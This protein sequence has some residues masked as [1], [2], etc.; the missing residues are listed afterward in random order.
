MLTIDIYLGLRQSNGRYT[1]NL[2][3]KQVE[4]LWVIALHSDRM[5]RLIS[6]LLDLDQAEQGDLKI[7]L[8]VCNVNTVMDKVLEA[9]SSLAHD[10]KIVIDCDLPEIPLRLRDDA[11]ALWRVFYN[12]IGNA[13]KYTQTGGQ[14]KIV[15]R[16]AEDNI[17]VQVMDNGYGLTL[18]QVSNLFA[19]YYRTEDG[20]ESKTAGTGIGLYIVKSLVE[21]HHEQIE[22]SSKLDEGSTFEVRLPIVTVSEGDSE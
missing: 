14:I 9:V 10:R 19:L 8:D 17:Y 2:L 16:R 11:G 18:E 5:N 12:P 20:K 6:D 4:Y 1:S 21:A 7:K 15:G 22:V 3:P 13:V